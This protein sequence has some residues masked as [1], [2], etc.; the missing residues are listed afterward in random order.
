MLT[1]REAAAIIDI[2]AVRT[3]DALP[4]IERTVKIA[5]QYRFINVHVLPCWIPELARLLKGERDIFIGSP[6]GFPSGA[7]SA[8]TKSF[9]A[10]QMLHDGVQ[11]MDIMMNVGKFK[12]KEYAYIKNELGALVGLA[13]GNALTK[14]I[15]EI[16]ALSDLEILKACD[17][18]IE[19]GADFVKTG[20]GWLQRNVNLDQINKIKR[21]CGSAI[22]VKA[23]GG[24]RTKEEFLALVDMGVERMGI[25][26][27]SAIEIVSSFDD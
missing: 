12:N 23:A 22:K 4:D 21:H 27:A 19:S 3:G 26:T 7:H 10:K 8:D 9:E 13:R 24:I 1:S 16:D 6:V 5:K 14:V 17:L 15:I 25:N 2:S 11:E 20:T 18:V